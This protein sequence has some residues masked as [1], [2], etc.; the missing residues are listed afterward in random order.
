MSKRPWFCEM[1]V[2]ARKMLSVLLALELC[3]AGVLVTAF[4]EEG[5][6]DQEVLAQAD[7]AIVSVEQNTEGEEP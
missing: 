5:V 2:R 7:G 6:D 4:A 1:G 3:V